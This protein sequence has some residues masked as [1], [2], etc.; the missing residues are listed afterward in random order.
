MRKMENDARGG[1]SRNE[2]IKAKSEST[3]LI[4]AASIVIYTRRPF[5][6]YFISQID[7]N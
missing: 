6:F 3:I 5:L 4:Y 2:I 1:G 7:I